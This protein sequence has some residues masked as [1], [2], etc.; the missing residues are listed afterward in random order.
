MKNPVTWLVIGAFTWATIIAGTIAGIA[1]WH[2]FFGADAPPTHDQA[3]NAALVLFVPIL[4]FAIAGLLVWFADRTHHLALYA[5]AWSIVG[6]LG[7]MCVVS[8]LAVFTPIPFVGVAL[9]I[10]VALLG[11]ALITSHTAHAANRA[12]LEL[13]TLPPPSPDT[14]IYSAPDATSGVLPRD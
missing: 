11:G 8:L 13:T 1:F 12:R 4:V 7:A 3:V 2:N 9:G 14:M 6:I 10:S 5:L